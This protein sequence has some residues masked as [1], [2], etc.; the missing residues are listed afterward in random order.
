MFGQGWI[1]NIQTYCHHL[2]GERL[3]ITPRYPMNLHEMAVQKKHAAV[4]VPLCNRHN[5]ASVLFTVRTQHVSTHKG[6][7][8]FP[9]GH[10]EPGETAIETAIREAKEELG[11]G[12]GN[13]RILGIGQTI[14]A[15]TGTLVTPVIGFLDKDVGDLSHLHPSEDEVSAIFTRSLEELTDPEQKIYERYQRE[16]RVYQMPVFGPKEE[17]RIW[18]ITAMILDAVLDKAV[19]PQRA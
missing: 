17:H 19:F 12:I 10:T 14:Y 6:Q 4:L 15:I 2:P 5:Q 16:G 11:E 18:G 1:R 3:R 13:I 8:S 7:V 9:G